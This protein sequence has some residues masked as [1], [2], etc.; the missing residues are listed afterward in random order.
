MSTI[1]RPSSAAAPRR[2]PLVGFFADG[3][4]EITQGSVAYRV[5]MGALTFVMLCGAYAYS[6]QLREGLAV[7]GMNDHGAGH[8][9]AFFTSGGDGCRRRDLVM[10]SYVLDLDFKACL[11]E[12]H[13]TAIGLVL[14]DRGAR[15][16]TIPASAFS[17]GRDRCW[18][19]TS[20][21]RH[22][23]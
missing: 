10:P 13:T 8:H 9:I 5:W 12:S 1:V 17:T 15:I 22:L 16:C 18:P 2:S 3:L 20:C 21:G 4:R 14:V 6:I 7:T 11:L 23:V 19:G